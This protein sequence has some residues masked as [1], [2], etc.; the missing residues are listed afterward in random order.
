MNSVTR[1]KRKFNSGLEHNTFFCLEGRREYKIDLNYAF[2]CLRP[3]CCFHQVEVHQFNRPKISSYSLIGDQKSNKHIANGGKKLVHT[4][5]RKAV[6]IFVTKNLAV[7]HLPLK[8][9]PAVQT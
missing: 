5:K 8:A 4:F 7:N 6:Q 1:Y 2:H 9:F 3:P